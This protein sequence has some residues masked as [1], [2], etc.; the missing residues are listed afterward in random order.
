MVKPI[1]EKPAVERSNSSYRG[2]R[3][4]KWGKYVSEIRLPNSRQRIWLGSYDTAEKAARAFDAAM[5]C[6]R[7][8]GA[9]FNFPSNPPNIAGGRSMTPSQIQ[10]AVARFANSESQ[11]E[12]S[13]QP[14]STSVDSSISSEETTTTTTT[15]LPMESPS[16]LSEMTVQ[17]DSDVASFQDLFSTFGPGNFEID[18]PSF[19][20]FDDF[21]GDFYVPE[22]PNFNY[23]ENL[24][25]LIIEDSCLWSF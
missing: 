7:G 18:F 9:N 21:S 19:P 24:D 8:S 14:V 15:L 13:G 11:N 10:I 25:G 12:C 3:K 23:E 17:N 1:S 2:V 20:G 6:L 22:L 16:P 4:R 5:F